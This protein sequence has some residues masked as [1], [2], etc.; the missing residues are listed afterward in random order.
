MESGRRDAL[1]VAE[2]RINST[3]QNKRWPLT[4]SL[5]YF[6]GLG[7]PA[8][9]GV[10]KGGIVATATSAFFTSTLQTVLTSLALLSAVTYL[11]IAPQLQRRARGR[12]LDR[13]LF[14]AY[15]RF[16]DPLFLDGLHEFEGI[17]WSQGQTVLAC[18]RPE[19]GWRTR[20]IS[21]RV[22]RSQYSFDSLQQAGMPAFESRNVEEG[23]KQFRDSVF[24]TQF[25]DD[26]VR[27]M[28]VRRPSS[29]TDALQLRLDLQTTCWSQLQYF[30]QQ[31]A[32]PENKPALYTAALEADPIPYPTSL[33]LHLLV[34]SS[35]GAL[36]LTQVHSAKAN[37]HPKTW[38]C[39]IGEQLAPEDVASL[40]EDCAQKWVVRA[41][42]EEMS[43]E[44]GEYDAEQIR[45]LAL[46]F[47]GDIANLAFVCAVHLRLSKEDVTTRLRTTN[48]LDN[49]FNAIDFIG[50]DSVPRELVSPSREYHPSTGIRMVYAYLHERGQNALR[51][52]LAHELHLRV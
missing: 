17:G 2:V 30:W 31:I 46:T 10:S 4:A 22:N 15:R 7:L 41:L 5:G 47:E 50:L 20:E 18:P 26:A 21:F 19:V 49:E 39:S 14:K 37:D 23:Y 35:E 28:L 33:A 36:L 38:A 11:L 43:I 13:S 34:F 42:H 40:D 16:V 48:R 45:F 3:L 51:R 32:T 9:A 8:V 6:A 25:R 27:L 12:T 29:F 24:P 44:Q 52:S 1:L